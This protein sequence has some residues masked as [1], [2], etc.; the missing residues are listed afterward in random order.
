VDP[1]IQI[2]ANGDGASWFQTLIGTAGG[3]IDY[4]VVHTYPTYNWAGYEYYR[5]NTP[6][7]T[8]AVSYV[9]TLINSSAYKDKLK[10]AVTETNSID[11]ANAWKNDNTLGHGLALFEVI[12]EIMKQPKVIFTQ[13]WNT[14]WVEN[15]T[16][17]VPS[18]YDALSPKNE[19]Y[20]TGQAM[21]MWGQFLQETLVQISNTQFI[22]SYASYSPV[23]NS[24]NIFL[25]NKDIVARTVQVSLQNY[26]GGMSGSRYV[27][28]G[29]GSEDLAPVWS[30][31]G[32]ISGTNNTLTVVL[33]PVSLSTIVLGSTAQPTPTITLIPTPIGDTNG[34]NVVNVNDLK[35]VLQNWLKLLTNSVDQIRDGR[36]NAL[37]FVRVLKNL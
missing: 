5:T 24:M 13:L 1:T 34:D 27:L 23:K 32:S 7:L 31:V 14:R 26:T 20:A 2:G 33:E 16:N 25:I 11:W 29:T 18:V 21:R 28:K 19:L 8:D 10:I 17:S 15:N 37:D 12:G 9:V 6:V 22:R 30:E 36:I 4:L 35:N 3:D